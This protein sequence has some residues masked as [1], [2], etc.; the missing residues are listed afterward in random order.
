VPSA[1]D[2]PRV[3]T[4]TFDVKPIPGD[5]TLGD[6]LPRLHDYLRLHSP[7]HNS[8]AIQT[9]K[10]FQACGSSSME[11]AWR[12]KRGDL[13]GLS[14][15][16]QRLLTITYDTADSWRLFFGSVE[17]ATLQ[18]L[19]WLFAFSLSNAAEWSNATQKQE[20]SSETVRRFKTYNRRLDESWQITAAS[21]R[22]F[23]GPLGL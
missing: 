19:P 5:F 4:S 3:R 15:Q 6:F 21:E 12:N 7:H 22:F 20:G 14:R 2:A 10:R 9:R 8:S 16:W 18:S 23:L 1:I 17:P 11:P 13:T